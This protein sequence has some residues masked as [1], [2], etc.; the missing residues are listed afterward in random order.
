MR[1]RTCV[2]MCR[3]GVRA[4]C[5]KRQRHAPTSSIIRVWRQTSIH[6]H[7]LELVGKCRDGVQGA[8][9]P[10]LRALKRAGRVACQGARENRTHD[11]I[12]TKCGDEHMYYTYIHV[13]SANNIMRS[14]HTTPLCAC[15]EQI[16]T[17]HMY[18][19]DASELCGTL[20][21]ALIWT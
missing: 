13:F 19:R 16:Y 11:C 9:A 17:T 2:C 10:F 18:A 3:L 1:T 6:P 21:R 20:R 5:T 7:N 14:H 8:S 4:G 15:D 12:H